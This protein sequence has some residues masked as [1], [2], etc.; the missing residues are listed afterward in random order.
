[1]EWTGIPGCWGIPM[2]MDVGAIDTG[3]IPGC[4]I[5]GCIMPGCIIGCMPGCGIIPGM[6]EAIEWTGMTDG[7]G[8]LTGGMPIGAKGAGT[9][10]PAFI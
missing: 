9:P 1:M 4:C 2:A 5:P 7:T 10:A 8:A 6:G 3:G